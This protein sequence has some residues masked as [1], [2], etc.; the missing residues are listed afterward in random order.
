MKKK[1]V[2]KR[3]E[4]YAGRLVKAYDVFYN[5]YSATDP[6]F[7]IFLEKNKIYNFN[8][9]CRIIL[10]GMLFSFDKNKNANDLIYTTPTHYSIKNISDLQSEFVIEHYA[11]LDKVLK[12]LKFKEDLTQED[13]NRISNI[14]FSKKSIFK[15]HPEIFGLIK[16]DLGLQSL[17]KGVL[18]IE[19]YPILDI[20]SDL[21][22]IPNPNEPNHN[23]ITKKQLTL[24]DKIM[25]K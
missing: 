17:E 4:V 5:Y 6:E 11:N 8:C 22:N 9:N 21:K 1:Y 18:P 7:V 25:K 20:Y 14:L 24:F 12:Y 13:L 2:I 16:T 19:L 3:N 15:R 10:R 23:L